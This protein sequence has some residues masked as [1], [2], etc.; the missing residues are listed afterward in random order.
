MEEDC[1]TPLAK[2]CDRK[3][4]RRNY[5][6]QRRADNPGLRDRER[7]WNRK[8]QE[9]KRARRKLAKEEEFARILRAFMVL[10]Q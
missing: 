4:A 5:M 8:Y 10:I 1:E 2:P 6:S 7:E 9:D 3:M